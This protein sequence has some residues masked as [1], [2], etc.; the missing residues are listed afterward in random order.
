VADLEQ[1]ALEAIQGKAA[2]ATRK[3]R[4]LRCAVDATLL[5]LA[6][7]VCAAVS[8]VVLV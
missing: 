4:L 7:L 5:S 1:W 8:A 2:Y 3:F 6:F